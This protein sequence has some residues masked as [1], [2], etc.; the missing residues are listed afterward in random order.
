MRST[1][2]PGFELPTPEK[3]VLKDLRTVSSRSTR[4]A[5]IRE[6]YESRRSLSGD[7]PT[8][9]RGETSDST[10]LKPFV[11]REDEIVALAN[12]LRDD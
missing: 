12:P 2:N 9:V 8:A 11:G 10:R 6:N 1:A 3:T 7:G 5:S 4:A